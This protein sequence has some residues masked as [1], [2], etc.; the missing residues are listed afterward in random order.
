[1]RL[2]L[3]LAFRAC[4]GLAAAFAIGSAVPAAQPPE[5]DDLLDKAAEFREER[6]GTLIRT[7]GS[8]SMPVKK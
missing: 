3:Q 7:T 5:L 1:M 6:A 8:Q 2:N 4:S